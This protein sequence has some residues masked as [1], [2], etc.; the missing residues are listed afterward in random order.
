MGLDISTSTI[1]VGVIEYNGKRFKL[2]HQEYYKPPKNDEFLIRLQE[3]KE[4]LLKLIDKHKPNEIGIEDFARHMQ[5]KS[6][7]KTIISLAS[8]NRMAGLAIL[9]HTGKIPTIL[10]VNTVRARMKKEL[11][12]K[13]RISKEE[14]PERIADILKIKFPYYYKTNRKTKKQEVRVESVDVG[15]ALAVAFALVRVKN[16]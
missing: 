1:G 9:E 3:T 2:K 15:D 16:L 13:D 12:L 10:N 7:A 14:V 8:I 6:T 11:S 5:G 4:Y